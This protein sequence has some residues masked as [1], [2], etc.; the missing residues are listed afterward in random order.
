VVAPRGAFF[1]ALRA[2]AI[3][4][5]AVMMDQT[6]NLGTNMERNNE[7]DVAACATKVATCS[8]CRPAVTC[9]CDEFI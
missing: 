9:I 3:S 7:I 4:L 1:S 8:S 2:F 6:I 5:S